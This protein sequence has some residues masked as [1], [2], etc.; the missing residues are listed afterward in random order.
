MIILE[1]TSILALSS[2]DYIFHLQS[3]L[4][5]MFDYYQGYLKEQVSSWRHLPFGIMI[6]LL[7]NGFWKNWAI[8]ELVWVRF[9]H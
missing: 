5:A 2:F 6:M 8:T 4:P 7:L 1:Q 3:A 9:Y